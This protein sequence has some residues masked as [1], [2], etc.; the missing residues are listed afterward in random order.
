MFPTKALLAG[1]VLYTLISTVSA[2]PRAVDAAALK[3]AGSA[4][5]PLAG[6][7]VTYGLTQGETRYSPLNQINTSNVGKLGLS[8]SLELGAGGGNQEATPLVWNNTIYAITNFSVV[9]AVDARNGKQVW[10]WDPEVN[11]STVPGK[12]C[13]G[14]VNRGLAM[15]NGLVF[16]PVNDGRLVALDA[17]TGT[18]KWEARLAY[19]QD[20]YSLTMAP[21]IAGN[22][23]VVGVA[24]GDHPIRGFFDAY[25]IATGKRAW[26]FYTVPGDPSK[27]FEDDAQRAAA[28]TWGGD[29][30]KMGGGGSVWDGMAY[31]VETNT[32]FAGTGNAEP[33]VEKFRGA[34][35]LD[36]LYTCSI[37]AVDANTG[38]LKWHYQTVPNDN[39]DFDAV[40]QLMLA[41]LQING[42][43]RKVIMQAPK[44][45]IFYVLDRVTGEFLSAAPFVQVNWT[46]GFDPKT[47]R[48]IINPEAFYDKTPVQIYPTGGGAHNWAPMS[49]NPATGLVYLPASFGNYTFLAADEVIAAPYGHT[50]TAF[51]RGGTPIVPPIIGPEPLAGQRGVLE[52]WDPVNQKLVWRT[53]GG[54]AAGGGTVTTAGNLVFQVIGN[55]RLLAY[56]AD[57]GEKLLEI[58]TNRNA[59]APPITYVV[60]GT[61]YVAFLAG[62]GRRP[63]Q[64][65]PTDAKVDNPPMLFVFEVGGTAAL[66]PPAA[67]APNQFAPPPPTQELHK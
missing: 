25:E 53:P 13:C 51:P 43:T 50:G 5:D 3:A 28:K 59:A 12:M 19:T 63:Q 46:K 4:K 49:Y 67:A 2:Q 23:V 39:W 55:G 17:L 33:W 18:V 6:S 65:G 7:W 64:A 36:N 21:R 24:G 42:R 61:Q 10:R 16:A 34:K 14:V 20:W 58:P 56:S 52:A 32:V 40:G 48:P 26:R 31:D 62:A 44:N 29:F 1:S 35:G 11:Q 37:V 22:K 45:G 60:D 41:D 15:A 30:W 38:K 27:G 66:P 47:G 57:K 8:W 54:G 9:Y